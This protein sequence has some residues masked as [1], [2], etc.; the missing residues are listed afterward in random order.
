[1]SSTLIDNLKTLAALPSKVV[2]GQGSPSLALYVWR[3]AGVLENY[4]TGKAFALAYSADQARQLLRD[5][6]MTDECGPVWYLTSAYRDSD[7][8]DEDDK[9][10]C[11]AKLAF[12]TAEPEVFTEPVALY[13]M[14]SE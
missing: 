13:Q 4:G 10:E 2:Y 9:A 6:M 11:A 5:K 7:V 1:M 8:W 12:L 14:G 3:G